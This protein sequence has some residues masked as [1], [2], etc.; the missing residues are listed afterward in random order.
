MLDY[1]RKTVR[2]IIDTAKDRGITR[3]EPLPSKQRVSELLQ[4]VVTANN[5]PAIAQQILSSYLGEVTNLINDKHNPL[6]PKMAFEVICERHDLTISYSSYKRF[7]RTNQIS[8]TPHIVTCRLEVA[9]GSEVQVDYAK[10]GLL[11]D[12]LTQKNRTVYAFIATLSNSRHKYVE[13]V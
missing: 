11:Y 12:P 13:F 7:V 4:D 10:M 8:L 3:D 6:K 5:R 9:P 2:K 1:D